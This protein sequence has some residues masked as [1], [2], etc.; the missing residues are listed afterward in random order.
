[1][2]KSYGV[3]LIGCGHIGEQHIQEIYD[4]HEATI[5]ATIDTNESVAREFARRFEAE[6]YGTDYRPFLADPRVEIVIIATY[7]DTHFA[8]LKDCIAN[9]KHVICEK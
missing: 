8:I 5:I 6:H 4:K 3:I 2:K 9:G 7:T 1:M